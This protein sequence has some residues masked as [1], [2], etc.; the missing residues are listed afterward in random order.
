MVIISKRCNKTGFMINI[1]LLKTSVKVF[2]T[3]VTGDEQSEF[4]LRVRRFVSVTSGKIE[5]FDGMYLGINILLNIVKE[6]IIIIFY[7]LL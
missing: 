5:T 4:S 6:F 3:L 1:Y 2:T 7:F